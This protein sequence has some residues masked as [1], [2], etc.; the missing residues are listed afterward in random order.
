MAAGVQIARG[1]HGE[2]EK[3]V[4]SQ[5]LEHVIEETEARGHDGLA[6]AVQPQPDH[7]LRLPGIALHGGRPLSGLRF[8]R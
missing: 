8:L 3:T 7:D 5:K 6:G 2:V 1:L 4:T